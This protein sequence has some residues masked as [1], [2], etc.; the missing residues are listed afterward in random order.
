M[1]WLINMSWAWYMLECMSYMN[2]LYGPASHE[3]FFAQWLVRPTGAQK[4]I[5]SIT[6]GNS[7]FF[8]VPWYVD[9]IIN[10]IS[11][12]SLKFTIFLYLSIILLP[13]HLYKIKMYCTLNWNHFCTVT[14]KNNHSEILTSTVITFSINLVL[15]LIFKALF[16]ACIHAWIKYH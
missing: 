8:F 3:F 14:W 12:P 7:D 2:L 6:V 16:G 15:L 13:M 1:M 5:G 4:V 9:H 11:S 10:L